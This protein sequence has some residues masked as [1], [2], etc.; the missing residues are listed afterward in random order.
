MNG[1]DEKLKAQIKFYQQLNKPLQCEDIETPFILAIPEIILSTYNKL[2]TNETIE[3]EWIP[4]DF[5]IDN[6]NDS[7]QPSSSLFY[8]EDLNKARKHLIR[9]PLELSN[10]YKLY[11]LYFLNSNC[12]Q[13]SDL[14]SIRL[15]NAIKIDNRLIDEDSKI[16]F[17]NS[18]NDSLKIQ[19]SKII[20]YKFKFAAYDLIGLHSRFNVNSIELLKNAYSKYR[21]EFGDHEFKF[22]L[23]SQNLILN[24]NDDAHGENRFKDKD[25]LKYSLRSVEK[26]LS[27]I[28]NIYIVTNGQ[29][30]NWLNLNDSKI[31]IINHSDLFTNQSHLPTF[32]S[33]AIESHL[34]RINGLSKKFIYLNDDFLFGARVYL[35]DFYSR[36][37]GYQIRLGW[38]VPNC[39]TN[40]PTSWLSDGICDKPCNSS[41]CL[42]D[43]GDCLKDNNLKLDDKNE[44]V[45]QCSANC[46]LSW[47]GD[48]H[49]DSQCNNSIC[50]FDLG[51]CK[52]AADL[53]N[54]FESTI[55]FSNQTEYEFNLIESKQGIF[56]NLTDYFI[57]LNIHRE[58]N[59]VK[60]NTNNWLP[61]K[62]LAFNQVK[63]LVFILLNRS[64][65]EQQ[66]QRDKLIINLDFELKD[67]FKNN[68]ILVINFKKS[69]DKDSLIAGTRKLMDFYA[70]SLTFSNY[71]MNKKYSIQNRKVPAHMPMLLDRDILERMNIELNDEI[72][73]TS[74]HRFR[75]SN[76][77]QFAFT[78]FY[79]LMSEQF[80]QTLQQI[81]DEYD[82]DRDK[83]LNKNE[84]RTFYLATTKSQFEEKDF[85]LFWNESLSCLKA[86][87]NNNRQQKA[88][89]S[90]LLNCHEF[91]FLNEESKVRKRNEFTIL[92]IDDVSFNTIN[93]DL[94]HLQS[95]LDNVRKS[96]KQFICIN[97]NYS[98]R[99]TAKTKKIN[100]ILHEFYESILPLKSKFE[101]DPKST[102]AYLSQSNKLELKN[103]LLIFIILSAFIC[104]CSRFCFY[105]FH[106]SRVSSA[107]NNT[108]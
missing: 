79:F 33:A 38:N 22:K 108:V 28:R 89:V 104:I 75:N 46:P 30:P 59:H 99:D 64:D 48:N 70:D 96:P 49:C 84:A 67:K 43:G 52:I 97:D 37:K 24:A 100:E 27:W 101:I 107:I 91:G 31:K 77:L 19:N 41:F 61:V 92:K 65:D 15:R 94:D 73:E 63:N 106:R 9:K 50:G 105:C 87:Q 10:Y 25:E 11:Q 51:D 26:Y 57:K 83:H 71:I 40:C 81:L 21:I 95:Q 60:L 36:S 68:L 3:K 23:I 88:K 69:N 35:E 66:Q 32:N 2:I 42:F 6:E 102:A 98:Y 80:Y 58:I 93:D 34:H 55:Y 20:K 12:N 44:N 7:N 82:I 72:Q 14:K 4:I 1:S 13:T 86:N 53:A 74:S 45:K 18:L 62:K 17:I 8:F 85:N 54:A 56:I 29:I 39:A 78:Y 90:I 16:K 76:D 47:L 5:E 103:Y